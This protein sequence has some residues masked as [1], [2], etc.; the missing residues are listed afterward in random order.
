MRGGSEGAG[1]YNI[2]SD[3]DLREAARKL[4]VAPKSRVSYS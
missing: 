4:D 3:S 2:V 1:Q